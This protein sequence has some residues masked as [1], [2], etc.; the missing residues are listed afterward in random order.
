MGL[1]LLVFASRGIEITDQLEDEDKADSEWEVLEPGT[2]LR[3]WD[4]I[5]CGPPPG[6]HLMVYLGDGRIMHADGDRGVVCESIAV[7]W[8]INYI[9]RL[10]EGR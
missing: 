4:L 10:K 1:V 9:L 5:V 3:P 7:V 2:N 6:E 8:R